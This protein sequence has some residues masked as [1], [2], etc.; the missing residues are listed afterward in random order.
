[1][2]T[3]LVR[4]NMVSRAFARGGGRS[5]KGA[6]L[7]DGDRRQRLPLDKLED[8]AAAGRDVGD[9]V[10]DPVLLDG[11]QR[12]AAAGEREGLAARYAHGDGARA[13]AEL[14]ELED[15][16]RAV[17]DDGAGALQ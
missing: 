11:G 2:A 5:S 12:V 8:G 6:L 13:L 7:Q 16:H 14:R 3:I 10:L 9:A 15:S 4:L 17:P 1:V